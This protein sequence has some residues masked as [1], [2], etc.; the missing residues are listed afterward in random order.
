M[1]VSFAR[2]PGEMMDGPLTKAVHFGY[3]W[4]HVATVTETN[5]PMD[6]QGLLTANTI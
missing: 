3:E 1:L 4:E 2:S 6:N 5:V